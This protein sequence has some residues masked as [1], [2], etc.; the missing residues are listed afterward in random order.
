MASLNRVILAGN[1]TRDP[2]VRYTPSGMA[3]ADLRLA[4]NERYKDSTTNEWKEKAVYV[5][6]VVWGRQAETSGQY[7]S[8]GSPVLIEGRLQLDQWENQQGEKRSKLR[9]NASRV[10]FLSGAGGQGR[11]DSGTEFADVGGGSG[12]D[13]PSEP[14]DLPPEAEDDENLPF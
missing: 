7:L 5:D 11:P 2:E 3:V 6:V 8:K 14:Q 10:Q 4:V 12:G 13:G 9:V 1:L